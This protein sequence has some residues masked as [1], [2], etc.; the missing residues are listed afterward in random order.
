[1]HG[2]LAVLVTG[3]VLLGSSVSAQLMRADEEGVIEALRRIASAQYAYASSCGSEFFAPSLEVL[4]RPAPASTMPFLSKA[5]VPPDGATVLEKYGYRI[6][7]TAAPSAKS[8]A[9]CS[10]VGVRG[11]A[12]TFHVVAR[13]LDDYSGKWF[14]MD[15]KGQITEIK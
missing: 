2:T 11:Q 13:T 9:G 8:P 12:E 14:E 1:M 3:L 4:H 15:G 7:M 5:H 10:G 6:E